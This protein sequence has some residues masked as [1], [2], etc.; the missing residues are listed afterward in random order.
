MDGGSKVRRAQQKAEAECLLRKGREMLLDF[1]GVLE[2]K[3]LAED[4]GGLCRVFCNFGL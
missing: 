2:R 4:L 3:I 1:Q